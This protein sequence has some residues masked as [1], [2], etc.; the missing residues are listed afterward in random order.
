MHQHISRYNTNAWLSF[1]PRKIL[2]QN[3]DTKKFKKWSYTRL[4][5]Q[6]QNKTG[7]YETKSLFVHAVP[8]TR[9]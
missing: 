4:K 6:K 2:Q 1:F 9:G 5:K 7:I 3:E 8:I